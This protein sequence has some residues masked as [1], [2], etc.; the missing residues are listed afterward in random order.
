[1]KDLRDKDKLPNSPEQSEKS[2][3]CPFTEHPSVLLV[4][5]ISPPVNES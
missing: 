5:G 4:D 1:M 2:Y 3:T